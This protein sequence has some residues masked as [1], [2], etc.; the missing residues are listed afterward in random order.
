MLKTVK[1]IKIVNKKGAAVQ[2]LRSW[3]QEFQLRE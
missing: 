2:L 1:L 3:D